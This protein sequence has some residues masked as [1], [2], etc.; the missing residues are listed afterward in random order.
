ME[1]RII[2]IIK[3]TFDIS[4]VADNISQKNCSKWDSMSHLNL[5]IALESEFDISIEP[6]EIAEMKT[7]A[8][9]KRI[10]TSK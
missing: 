8:D 1:E 5:I 4:E 2:K 7:L 6:E 10:I 3:S 9:I